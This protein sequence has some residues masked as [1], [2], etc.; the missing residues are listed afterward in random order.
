M[1]TFVIDAYSQRILGWRVATTMRTSLVLEALEQT[2]LDPAAGRGWQIYLAVLVCH[3]DAGSPSTP[4]WL[5]PVLP[6]E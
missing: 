6:G 5:R 4:R 3:N 2:F 1:S